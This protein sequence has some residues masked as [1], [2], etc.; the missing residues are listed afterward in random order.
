MPDHIAVE[1]ARAL[2]LARQ[3]LAT[4]ASAITTLAGRLGA[5]FVEAVGAV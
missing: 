2:A 5:P 4:E 3:V 1:P